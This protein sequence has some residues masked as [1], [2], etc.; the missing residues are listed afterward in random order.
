MSDWL[1]AGS[2]SLMSSLMASSAPS[3]TPTAEPAVFS[4]A[5]SSAMQSMGSGAVPSST[6]QQSQQM[7]MPH[8]PFREQDE[9]QQ[10]RESS[11]ANALQSQDSVWDLQGD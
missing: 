3:R 6:L 8:P 2:A 9:Q 4:R 1:G 7:T 11:R 10:E 5:V